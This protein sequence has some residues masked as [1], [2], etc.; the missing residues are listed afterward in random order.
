MDF[1]RVGL[2]GAP[3]CFE[4]VCFFDPGEVLLGLVDGNGILVAADDVVAFEECF[5][6]DRAGAAEGVQ[7]DF[8]C[9]EA[10]EIDKDFGKANGDDFHIVN[11]WPSEVALFEFVGVRDGDG[12]CDEGAVQDK[13]KNVCFFVEFAGCRILFLQG[14]D[15]YFFEV[16]FQPV[17]EEA[18]VLALV[19]GG[20]EFYFVCGSIVEFLLVQCVFEFVE[21]WCVS[22][23]LSDADSAAQFVNER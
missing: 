8:I 6:E 3:V 23:D 16:V 4:G 11:C 22:N 13:I 9:F 7:E 12:F 21:A 17:N 18:C 20:V 5:L 19:V 14:F 2:I 15:A 1:D 10:C